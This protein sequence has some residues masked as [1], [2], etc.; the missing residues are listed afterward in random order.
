MTFRSTSFS[1]T[2]SDFRLVAA[3]AVSL[4]LPFAMNGQGSRATSGFRDQRAAPSAGLPNSAVAPPSAPNGLTATPAS[5]I[6]VSLAW[7]QSTQGGNPIANYHVYSGPTASNMVQLAITTKTSYNDTTVTAGL[8]VYYSVQASDTQGNLSPMSPTVKVTVPNPPAPPTGVKATPTSDTNISVSWK[9]AV[10]GGAPLTIKSYTVFRGI[11]P[12]LVNQQMAITTQL[13]YNDATATADTTYYYA[14]LATDSGGDVSLMSATYQVTSFSPPQAPT[15]VTANSTSTTKAVV[16]WTAAVTGGLVVRN[17]SISRGTSPT[18]LT[19]SLGTTPNTTYNDTT[20]SAGVTYYYGVV[21]TDTGSYV[22]PMSVPGVVTVVMPPS[23]P[24]GLTATTANTTK[25]TL[26]WAAA[27][28]NGFPVKYYK[29]YRGTTPINILNALLATT[30]AITYTDKTIVPGTIYYYGVQ[31]EDSAMDLSAMSSV[32]P[33]SGFTPPQPPTGATATPLS[34]TRISVTWTPATAGTLA[35]S[36]YQLYRGTSPN[37]AFA[38]VATVAQAS[39]TDQN[40]TQKTTYYYAIESQDSGGD[41]S[42]M[43]ATASATVPTPPLPP[44]SVTP[45]PI[46][47]TKISVIWPPATSGGLPVNYYQ[48]FRGTAAN[49][50]SPFATVMANSYTDTNAVPG[51]TY[52]YAVEAQDSGGD[53][54]PMSSTG[55]VVAPALPSAPVGLTASATNG[56]IVNLSW[57]ASNNGGLP[58]AYYQ[59]YRNGS[60][61]TTTTQAAAIDTQRTPGATYSYYVIAQDSGNDVSPAS[62]AVTATTYVLPSAPTGLGATSAS[63]IAPGAAQ[64]TYSVS[65]RWSPSTGGLPIQFYQVL[66]GSSA[67]NLSQ[68]SSVTQ[69]QWTDNG[70]VAGTTYYYGI[71]AGDTGGDLSNQSAAAVVATSN[72]N[73]PGQFNILPMGISSFSPS[74]TL[75]PGLP[76]TNISGTLFDDVGY[77]SGIVMNNKV[78]YNANEVWVGSTSWMGAVGAAVPMPV[79]MAYDATQK[80]GGFANPSNWNWFDAST[81]SW[82][83]KSVTQPGNTGNQCIDP[84]NNASCQNIAGAYMGRSAS[85]GNIYYPTPD[86][87]NGYMVFLSYDTT[88]AIND[89]T[90]YQTFVPPGYYLSSMGEQYGWCSSATDG[91]FVYY[92]PL[93]NPVTGNS[94]NVFRY[95]TTQPFSNLQTGGQ[96]PAW[97][98]FNMQI[99]PANPLGVDPNAAGFQS[100]SYDGNRYI[101]YIP[102]QQTLIVRY[103]TWNGGSAPDPTGFQIP[104]NYVTFD[105]TQLNT[106]GYPTVAGQGN[107]A[108]LAG[109]TGSQVAWDANNNYEYLYLVPWG[110]YP[111]NASN[112]TLMSTALRV[113]IGTMAGGSWSPIDITSTAT[114]PAYTLPDWQMFDLTTLTQNPA[115][116]SNWPLL[117]ATPQFSTQEAIAG[118]QE[119]FVTSSNSEGQTFGPRVGFVPDTSQFVVEHDVSHDLFDPTGWYVSMIP[120]GYNYGTMG[121]GYDATNAILYP[122]SP[123]I[124]LFAFQF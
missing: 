27:Q 12:I 63:N 62:S 3:L 11:S 5:T 122:S 36:Y 44:S 100:A 61:F 68:V 75:F 123:N 89:P 66:R 33:S 39:Y 113:S 97:Q 49:S 80:L 38:Q 47:G 4:W 70:V 98:N 83:S 69:T 46:S 37:G 116:P 120:N 25:V 111:N 21:A 51:T 17:Y 118:W 94:G 93:G 112:P 107:P 109:F 2:Q 50:L 54:S 42:A 81:L 13:T 67:A 10:S 95:D 65:L 84:Q 29:V 9:A 88:K 102:F 15:N 52:Y 74:S 91:R 87:H 104:S 79:F 78:I 59:V 20:V 6:R 32:V 40:V 48:V 43:S 57:S 71:I 72:P 124:P 110:T 41:D 119:A 18:S 23:A 96:T 92:V 7:Q 26:T 114:A 14:L 73:A 60:Q 64:A 30:T 19:T 101:Y 24:T 22:S 1:L 115:W 108:N 121:G 99:E 106:A 90:A 31:A 16:T 53:V 45:S 34:T 35:I 117:Q 76:Q 55:T 105:P 86:F 85:V 77:Q 82:Y 28:G 8:V 56:T 58:I 103:D